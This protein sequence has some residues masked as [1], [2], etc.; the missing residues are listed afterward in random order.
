MSRRNINLVFLSN[1]I[2]N[3]VSMETRNVYQIGLLYY[4]KVY[5]NDTLKASKRQKC[6]GKLNYAID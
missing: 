4:F 1:C 5:P 2:I 3:Q 6:F